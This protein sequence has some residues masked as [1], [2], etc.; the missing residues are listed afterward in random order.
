MWNCSEKDRKST[1]SSSSKCF[2]LN[3]DDDDDDDDDIELTFRILVCKESGCIGA[4]EWSRIEA[5]SDGVR[6][7]EVALRML[8]LETWSSSGST[9]P[10]LRIWKVQHGNLKIMISSVTLSMIA[11]DRCDQCDN[12]GA[13]L[14]EWTMFHWRWNMQ[15]QF[16]LPPCVL[17]VFFW[18]DLQVLVVRQIKSPRCLLDI[19]DHCR[20]ISSMNE[21]VCMGWCELEKSIDDNSIMTCRE[22]DSR[23]MSAD[24]KSPRFSAPM[25][26]IQTLQIWVA[27]ID[28]TY[29][30]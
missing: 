27:M 19:Y 28:A 29:D 10:C 15:D 18:G 3:V 21:H 16:I 13:A 12:L 17:W 26:L 30:K 22:F 14:R 23:L 1:G 9:P 11:V 4:E 2:L 8:E 6:W 25:I 7:S 5:G 20:R 24:T